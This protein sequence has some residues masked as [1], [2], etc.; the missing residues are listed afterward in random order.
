M[1]T[2]LYYMVYTNNGEPM[3]RGSDTDPR[4]DF[5]KLVITYI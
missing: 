1:Y 3:T 2:I 5:Y 4:V